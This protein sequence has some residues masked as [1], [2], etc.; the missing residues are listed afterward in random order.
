MLNKVQL[1]SVLFVVYDKITKFY[2]RL[3]KKMW[4]CRYFL[5][6]VY[7]YLFD[8]AEV[9]NTF[10]ISHILDTEKFGK[11]PQKIHAPNWNSKISCI[12][13]NAEAIKTRTN[14]GNLD[15]PMSRSKYRQ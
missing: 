3:N 10:K 1:I 8:T 2:Q 13:C 11:E 12:L 4:L 6:P 9:E 14:Q 5:V 7:L 15:A